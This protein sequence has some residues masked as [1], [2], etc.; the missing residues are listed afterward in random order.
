MSLPICLGLL[1][2]SLTEPFSLGRMVPS[3]IRMLSTP[4]RWPEYGSEK[5]WLRALAVSLDWKPSR[6]QYV[7]GAML[8]VWGTIAM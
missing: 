4:T 3:G 1:Q 7:F 8:V 6:F 2:K 5:V